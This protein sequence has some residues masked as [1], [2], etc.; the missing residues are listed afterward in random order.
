M[1]LRSEIFLVVFAVLSA[2]C[3]DNLTVVDRAFD[4][5]GAPFFDC[6]PNLDGSLEANEFPLN[7]TGEGSYVVSPPGV[8]RAV[9]LD[10]A[11]DAA[12][13][14]VWPLGADFADD[15]LET[16]GAVPVS[17]FWFAPSFPNATFVLPS[18]RSGSLLAV[19]SVASDRL[20]L[21]GF[22]SRD[23]M[24]AE[25]QTLLP[26]EAPV[27]A[28]RFPFAAGNRWTE[29][30]TVSEGM[31]LG[32]AYRG[33]D[34]YDSTVVGAGTLELPDVTFTQAWQLQQ[35]ATVAPAVGDPVTV[36][37]VSFL[38]E[39]FGEVARATAPAGTPAPFSTAA[40]LRRYSLRR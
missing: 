17:D 14:R 39:C 13:R 23:A 12:G 35:T 3:T 4:P 28:I 22:A 20:L 31:A 37:S 29:T 32:L 15:R 21:H 19:Y 9:N 1:T 36:S 24:P 2:G 6:L 5:S 10:G 33:E 34:T 25:G 8:T 38:F 30:G 7:L 18:D 26:Y 11:V 16:E 40:E 27:A